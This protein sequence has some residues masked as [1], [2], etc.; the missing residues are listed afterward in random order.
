MKPCVIVVNKWDLAR[1]QGDGGSAAQRA[2]YEQVMQDLFFLHYASV[3]FLSAKTGERVQGLFTLIEK[4][5]KSRMFRFATGPLNRVITKAIEKHPPAMQGG[6]RLKVLYAT[7]E[8]PEEGR[9]QAIPVL[10]L[11]V[12]AAKL[13]SAS[14]QR[15]MDLQLREAFDIPGVP[16]RFVL[17]ERQQREAGDPIRSAAGSRP[18]EERKRKA[19]LAANKA[20]AK[21]GTHPIPVEAPIDQPVD[22]DPLEGTPAARP[23]PRTKSTS[24]KP[25]AKPAPGPGTKSTGPRRTGGKT[26][27]KAPPTGKHRR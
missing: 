11:F 22:V 6:R 15:Y 27:P 9:S 18:A 10:I 2:Y 24:T 25:R 5:D 13:W 3:A 23:K 7:Q 20:A 14:Y 21:A 12:N 17:R 16:I 19:V 26:Q 4:L 1:E 8:P